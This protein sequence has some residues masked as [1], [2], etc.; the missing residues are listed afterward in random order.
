MGWKKGRLKVGMLA[1]ACMLM[2]APAY[3]DP[4]DIWGMIA[5]EVDVYSSV[6]TGTPGASETGT[7]Y[8]SILGTHGVSD[9][10][11]A[12]Y[13]ASL[14]NSLYS[15]T[16]GSNVDEQEVIDFSLSATTVIDASTA[17]YDASYELLHDT[18]G[19]NTTTVHVKYRYTSAGDS[20]GLSYVKI[21]KNNNVVLSI[22]AGTDEVVVKDGSG[23][24]LESF[25]PNQ[26]YYNHNFLFERTY[27]LTFTT[28]DTL[29]LTGYVHV[30]A[31]EDGSDLSTLDV[32]VSTIGP[33]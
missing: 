12:A 6:S 3:G 7:T 11:W 28:G 18:G 10:Y 2:G 13:V 4:G 22:Q 15:V 19:S 30:Q 31:S 32:D 17:E 16:C 5:G 8:D 20:H 1:L 29:R 23:N 21:R 27:P 14:G 25:I 24:T 33:T 26:N 9:Q